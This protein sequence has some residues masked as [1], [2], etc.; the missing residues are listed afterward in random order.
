MI[1]QGINLQTYKQSG[2]FSFLDGL[3]HLNPYS[4][5]TPYPPAKTPSTPNGTLDG[6]LGTKDVLRSFYQTIK[7]HLESKKKPLLVLDD[8]SVLLQSG[9]GLREVCQ[10]VYKLKSLVESVDGT[11][12]TVCHA[13]EQGSEDIEQ[14]AFVK[15]VLTS[16]ELV[17]QVQALGSGLARDVHGQLSI[18]H[19]SKCMPNTSLNYLGQSLHYKILDNNVHFFAKG[20]SQGV[21]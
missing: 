18:L 12:V 2:Q 11:L 9:L 6:S 21:L 13:D 15:T 16:A 1:K 10:F 4:H 7:D 5:T 17:L 3:T 19:G 14:D 8:V 20:I